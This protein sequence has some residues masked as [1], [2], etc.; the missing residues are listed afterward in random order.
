MHNQ[1]IR[2]LTSSSGRLGGGFF[3]GAVAGAALGAIGANPLTVLA[4]MAIGGIVGAIGG[5][6]VVDAIWNWFG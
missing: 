2:E 3:G 6:K 1:Q 5:E 4:G